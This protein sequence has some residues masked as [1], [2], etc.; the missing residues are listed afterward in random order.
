MGL[1]SLWQSASGA[2]PPQAGIM[3]ALALLISALGFVRVVWFVSLG[4]AGSVSAIALLSAWLFRDALTPWS[5]LHAGLL[6]VYGVRLG[7]YL[8][9]RELL[10]AYAPA[11]EDA[12]Q[13]GAS[14]KL[15]IKPL[16]WVSVA[17][18]YVLM[19]APLLLMLVDARTAPPSGLLP[20]QLIGLAIAASGLGLEALADHQKSS[21]KAINPKR[22]CDVG[23]YRWV[24]CPNY[25]GEMIFWLGSFVA[26]LSALDH[27]LHWL[28]ALVGL[29]CIEL[30]MMGSTKR[31]EA[32][33]LE[34]YGAHPDYQRYLRTV[35]VLFPFVPVYSLKN[36]RVYL[37]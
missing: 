4:Y 21:F 11:R 22:W 18:L 30:I 1:A 23:L 10:P 33:Q 20:S 34:R 2:I 28:A 17:L 27:W 7:S 14:V 35:P 36:V 37:E 13:R 6:V 25:L 31:L 16:I 15:A 19:T 3:L 26:G 12:K 29:I 5:A 8:L 9:R 32:G 24:R